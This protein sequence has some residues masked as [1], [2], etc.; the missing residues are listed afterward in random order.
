ME[1][2][3]VQRTILM[4]GRSGGIRVHALVRQDKHVA[5]ILTEMLRKCNVMIATECST[6]SKTIFFS[7]SCFLLPSSLPVWALNVRTLHNLK[8]DNSTRIVTSQL[9][10]KLRLSSLLCAVRGILWDLFP[11]CVVGLVHLHL[12]RPTFGCLCNTGRYQLKD[13]IYTSCV[14]SESRLCSGLMMHMYRTCYCRVIWW[15][16]GNLLSVVPSPPTPSPH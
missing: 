5:G 9:S 12:L 13:C 16:W 8:C 3:G 7:F 11:T 2:E 10:Q 4:S 15:L 14:Y 1:R 6:D